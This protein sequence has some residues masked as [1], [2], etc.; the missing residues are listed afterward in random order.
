MIYE[1]CLVSPLKLATTGTATKAINPP[2][3]ALLR[4]SRTVY[5]EA[6]PFFQKNTFIVDYFLPARLKVMIEG[7]NENIRIL[8]VHVNGNY[9]K[10]Q[11]MFLFLQSCKSLKKLTVIYST[12]A[13][14]R[15]RSRPQRLYQ[16]DL[17][18]AKFSRLNGFDIL[19]SLRGL[20]KVKIVVTEPSLNAHYGIKETERLRFEDF[21][22]TKVTQAPMTEEEI[23]AKKKAA[24]EAERKLAKA[25]KVK[26]SHAKPRSGK[27]RVT[28]DPDDSQD[29]YDGTPRSWAH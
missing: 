2:N 16:D 26:A 11:E 20:E 7:L 27:K 17:T 29:E 1:T 8:E 4:T 28:L 12:G 3:L 14:Y 5:E 22:M 13:Q 23:A 18:L 25:K 15:R 19:C 6:A 10:D 9:V 21:L 24:L